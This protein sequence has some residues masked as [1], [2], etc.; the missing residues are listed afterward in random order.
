MTQRLDLIPSPNRSSKTGKVRFMLLVLAIAASI[1]AASPAVAARLD[2]WRFERDRNQLNFRTTGNVQPKAQLLSNPTRLIIDLPGTTLGQTTVRQQVGGTI[3][4]IRVGQFERQTSR[5]VVELAEGYTLDPDQVQFRGS[6]PSQW[7]VQLPTPQREVATSPTQTPVP[8]PPEVTVNSTLLQGIDVLDEG[9][10][11]RTSGPTPEIDLRWST[12]RT[13]VTLDLSG[14]KLSPEITE[15]V[16]K[17]DR[18]GVNRLEAIQV[19]D[20][21]LLSRVL[22]NLN[23]TRRNWQAQVTD[24]GEVVIWPQGETPPSASSLPSVATIESVE[25]ANDGTSVVVNSDRPVGYKT[26]WDIE[27]LAYKITLFSSQLAQPPQELRTP[28]QS[29]LLWVRTVEEDPETVVVLVQPAAGI[30]VGE[31]SQPAGK[32]LMVQLQPES[33]PQVPVQTPPTVAAG[34]RSVP[35]S[36]PPPTTQTPAPRTQ[37][38]A[39]S[40]PR[41]PTSRRV[42]VI[43]AGH[44]GSDPG[45]IGIGGLR[46]K[47]VVLDISQQVAQILEQNGVTVVMTRQDD[48]TIDLAPRTQLA[49]RVNANL[50]VSIHAN[51]ISMSRPD[52]N[53]LETYYFNSGQRLA[54]TIHRSMLRSFGNMRD[55]GV[56]RARFYV[57]RHTNMPAVLV[58]TGFVTGRDDARM[59][60]NPTERT[61]MAEA[62]AQG[63]LQYIREAR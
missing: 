50:F 51:A 5:I 48:R 32:Q 63:I 1:F 38:P 10:I 39:P 34:E 40:T 25:L 46:E 43:D 53:G 33:I 31:I 8:P 3:R 4:E 54:Q 7:S 44:G 14:V 24:L 37:T 23:D 16:M 59:L 58:E 30:R 41:V 22:L 19:S 36:V 35:I 6:S 17:V 52:V 18:L 11:L 15:R 2:S 26:E 57:L 27:T 12:D 47:E 21:P 42:V 28:S 56:R 29:S 9:F 61:R 60:A 45:A 49:N 62:I 55:R 13:W 20:S